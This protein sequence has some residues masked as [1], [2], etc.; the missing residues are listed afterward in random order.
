D[1]P[2]LDAIADPA[3]LLPNAG[4]Q[5]V[6][7][8][9]ISA[10]GGEAQTLTVTATS[11]NTSLIPN[12]VVTYTSPNPTGSL[13]YTPVAG[14]TGTAVITVSI[15]DGGT[16]THTASRTFAVAVTP[17]PVITSVA[18]ASGPAAG[19]TPVGIFGSG[20]TSR[21]TVTVGGVAPSNVV[22]VNSTKITAT[23]AAH[24]AGPVNVT[25]TNPDAHSGTLTNGFTYN[26]LPTN[27]NFANRFTITGQ[28]SL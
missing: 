4:P 3:A 24:A 13:A 9:G 14:A 18:P 22:V 26:T 15:V 5:T 25:V 21:V 12:P 16:G 23:T 8:T 1:P 19:G 11:S 20:F 28:G 17:P 2:T 27:D 7:L 6:S 10:G